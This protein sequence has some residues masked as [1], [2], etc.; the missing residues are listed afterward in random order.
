M[1][2][3]LDVTNEDDLKLL[4]AEVRG[5]DEL[6]NVVEQVQF[7]IIQ[8]FS[9]RDMQGLTTYESFFR[10]EFGVDPRDVIRVRLLGFDEVDPGQS[11]ADMKDVL[12]RTIAN[13]TSWVIR[14]YYNPQSVTM[15]K[16]GQ[17]AVSYSGVTPSYMDFPS[18]WDRLLKNFDAR[19]QPY[20]I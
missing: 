16:Q 10:Y 15:I 4:H 13:V 1:Y 9:Q 12:K 20:G 8:A 11:E 7:E 14:N 5:S 3:F 17:R 6:A 18:G 2:Q 19:I